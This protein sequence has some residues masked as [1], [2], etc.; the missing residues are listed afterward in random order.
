MGD[1]IVCKY[2][3]V[4]DIIINFL[5]VLSNIFVL[6]G[7]EKYIPIAEDI[8]LENGINITDTAIVIVH[9]TRQRK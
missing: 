3:Q 6:T 9:F 8:L 2:K 5:F 7:E 4:I 1:D